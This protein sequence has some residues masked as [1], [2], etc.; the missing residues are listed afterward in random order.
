MLLLSQCNCVI[1][2]IMLLLTSHTEWEK[3]RFSFFFLSLANHMPDY[4]IFTVYFNSKT[5]L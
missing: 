2:I 5:F 3:N 4:Y 1:D